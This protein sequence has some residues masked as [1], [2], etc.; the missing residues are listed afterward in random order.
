[1]TYIQTIFGQ[2]NFFFLVDYTLT[3]LQ[4][5]QLITRF[6]PSRSAGEVVIHNGP[7]VISQEDRLAE[8]CVNSESQWSVHF[9]VLVGTDEFSQPVHLE[10]FSDADDQELL[11][12]QAREELQQKVMTYMQ[13]QAEDEE[14][15]K[16]EEQ[17]AAF[18]AAQAKSKK[19]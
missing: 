17:K 7:T 10:F 6:Y 11:L 9:R 14:K 4:I 13:Q 15:K 8:L 5:A 2:Q 3:A 19:K 18:E 16:D 12:A 1:M